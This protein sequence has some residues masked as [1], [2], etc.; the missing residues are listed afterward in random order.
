VN[1]TALWS[2]QVALAGIMA[3]FGVPKLSK[4]KPIVWLG[5]LELA[6]AVGVI[7]PWATGIAP[8]LTPLAA[9][10][11][12]LLMLGAAAVNVRTGNWKLL[13]TT[14]LTLALAAFVALG[15]RT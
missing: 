13:P 15:R 6:A 4:P 2:A 5:V 10:G 9:A 7:V 3:A 1:N 12:V 14:L 11:I 8:W